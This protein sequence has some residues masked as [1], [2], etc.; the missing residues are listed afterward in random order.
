MILASIARPNLTA[1]S[2]TPR[3]N[4][5]NTPGNAISTAHAWAL[6]VAPKVVEAPEETVAP[7][8]EIE[9]DPLDLNIEEPAL[10]MIETQ[11]DKKILIAKKFVL[12]R[13]VLSKV[14]ENLGHD[15]DALDDMNMLESK[16]ASGDYDILFTDTDL[17]TES[18]SQSNGNVAIIS[19]SNTNDPQEVSVQKGETISKTASKEETANI[20]TKYR[21]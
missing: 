9:D 4:T 8:T 7:V 3:F 10:D 5:G 16:L 20:I 11:Q 15:Y 14:L 12:A 21:G 18:I 1:S 2:T 17:L 13:R 6:G 19:S